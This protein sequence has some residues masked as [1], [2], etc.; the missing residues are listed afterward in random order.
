MT[1]LDGIKL[2][3]SVSRRTRSFDF[4][5]FPFPVS[6]DI[7]CGSMLLADLESMYTYL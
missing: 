3:A 4:H 2:D 1:Y 5:L 6:V 7:L